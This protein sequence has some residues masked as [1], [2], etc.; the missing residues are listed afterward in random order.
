[1]KPSMVYVTLSVALLLL[2]SCIIGYV[3]PFYRFA[4]FFTKQCSNFETSRFLSHFHLS[5]I[6]NYAKHPISWKSYKKYSNVNN[7]D[8]CLQRRMACAQIFALDCI[9]WIPSH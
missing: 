6:K 4:F 2:P 9:R 1:M 3:N 5:S 8:L 7:F